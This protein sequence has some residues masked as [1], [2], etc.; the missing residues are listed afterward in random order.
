MV[1]DALS[2]ARHRGGVDGGL[3]RHDE[4]GDDLPPLGVVGGHDP[5]V[6]RLVE[7][8][9]APADGRGRDGEAAGDDDVVGPAAHLD[10]PGGEDDPDV[11]GD[12]PAVA[13][14]LEEGLV[15]GEV[16]RH[17]G[18]ARDGEAHVDALV[19]GAHGRARQG[20]AVVDAAAAGLGHP[21]A[22]DDG[23]AH[24][25][26]A[27]EQQVVRGGPAD[28]D[29][30]QAPQGGDDLVPGVQARGELGGHDRQ[31]AGGPVP[32]GAFDSGQQVAGVEAVGAV[33]DLGVGAGDCRAHQHH[34]ARYVV[35]GQG[36]D[37]PAGAR[38]RGLG[39]LG[40]GDQGVGGDADQAWASGA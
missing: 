4:R 18:V 8:P 22:G 13:A 12:E 20:D 6:G 32:G 14:L 34:R 35:G 9:D 30:G 7:L 33:D 3:A 40:G 36:Q 5:R 17:Q 10:Q 37:P 24:A 39:G 38:Q 16:A 31:V 21:V 29:R 15:A 27:L 23:Q 25:L 11:G 28:E 19:D 2:Q 1:A 26:G